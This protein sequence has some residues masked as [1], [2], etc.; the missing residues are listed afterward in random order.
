MAQL[1]A[2]LNQL[3]STCFIRVLIEY[4]GASLYKSKGDPNIDHSIH[5]LSNVG[6]ST[7]TFLQHVPSCCTLDCEL[8]LSLLHTLHSDFTAI[9]S[10]VNVCT[11][12]TAILFYV[13]C[14]AFPCWVANSEALPHKIACNNTHNVYC[15]DDLIGER[16]TVL[17]Y[18]IRI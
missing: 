1:C 14:I 2:S 15:Q 10:S 17:R 3:T 18:S 16:D 9:L 4:S 7:C 11:Y 12:F 6:Q 13:L 8:F 5:W